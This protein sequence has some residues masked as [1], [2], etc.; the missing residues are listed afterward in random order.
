M[1]TF[2]LDNGKKQFV[3]GIN[4][5]ISAVVLSTFFAL[6]TL[7]DNDIT[8]L[9]FT[10]FA[11]LFGVILGLTGSIKLIFGAVVYHAERTSSR[12]SFT[13]MGDKARED[14]KVKTYL[15]AKNSKK[16]KK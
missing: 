8:K 3:D 11:V 13:I 7:I 9:I 6:L 5:L 4:C 2:S 16:N 1:F 12:S 14:E 15:E 10:I